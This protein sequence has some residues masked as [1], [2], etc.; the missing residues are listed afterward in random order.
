[1]DPVFRGP[2]KHHLSFGD[3]RRAGPES[4]RPV[5]VFSLKLRHHETART[6]VIDSGLS[7]AGCPGMTNPRQLQP[8]RLRLRQINPP[9]KSPK[10]CP[11]LPRKISRFS[12][13]PNHLPMSCVPFLEEGR[14]AIVT[15][16]GTGCGGRER[17]ARRAVRRGRRSRV[18]R[19]PRRWRQVAM[20]LRITPRTV[21][22]KPD[23]RGEHEGNR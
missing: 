13:V 18:V 15:T 23:H 21:T 3:A 6:G 4:I 12:F 17:T 2:T 7:P 1:M 11:A 10:T 22:R 16:R 19:T 20:M 8:L 5:L 14:L 9:G